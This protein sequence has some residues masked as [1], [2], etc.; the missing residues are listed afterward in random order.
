MNR[1]PAGRLKALV[2]DDDEGVRAFAA[3]ALNSFAPGF[4]VATARDV[5]EAILWLGAFH[6]D[7]LLI[8]SRL[9]DDGF[10]AVSSAFRQ[11]LRN[12]DCKIVMLGRRSR[13]DVFLGPDPIETH[14]LLDKPLQLRS[15]LQTV[16]SLLS[17]PPG[18]GSHVTGRVARP[19][20]S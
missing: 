13:L 8:D 12:K 14:G 7:L 10:S 6:P 20:L 11:D 4:D 16:Q 15:L 17:V 19:Y 3:E 1:L 18:P 5:E 9:W 2:I